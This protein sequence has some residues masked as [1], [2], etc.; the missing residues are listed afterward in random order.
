MK[1]LKIGIT[2]GIGSGK[3]RVASIF[4]SLGYKIYLADDRAKVLMHS[5]PEVVA[6]VTKVFGADAYYPD[7]Q[8]NRA[9][10]GGIVFN[11]PQKLQELN[12]IVHPATGRDF[13]HWVSEI[14][15]SYN[16]RLVFKEAAILFESGAYLAADG[17]I[18]V[19]APKSIRI[20]RVMSRDNTDEASVLARM[21][22]QWPENEKIQRA[23]FVIV[24][25]GKNLLAPQVRKAIQFFNR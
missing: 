3:S 25:D 2:G 20:E 4:E 14:P 6:S 11:D 22:K 7:G 8:L 13:Q 19:Y 1:L 10:L 17:V 16:K 21:D 5:D 18:T 24:N 15:D 9:Y 23:D 12:R